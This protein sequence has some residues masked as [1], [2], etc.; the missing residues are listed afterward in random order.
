RAVAVH[1]Q[2]SET[3]GS[4]GYFV[5]SATNTG[6]SRVVFAWYSSYGGNAATASF[7]SRA[8]SEASSTSRPAMG[9]P[10]GGAPAHRADQHVAG[11]VLHPHERRLADRAG[12]VP[13]VRHDDDRQPGVAQ[14]GPFLAAAA[15]IE[16]DLIADPLPWTG[17]VL[18][19]LVSSIGLL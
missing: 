9:R 16:I 10:V 2:I 1:R 5:G 17:D 19:H 13:A 11:A 7:H 15:L 12:L 14:R 3:T 6:I 18:S 4:R 8:R